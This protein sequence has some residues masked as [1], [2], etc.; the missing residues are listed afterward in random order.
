MHLHVPEA[1][2]KNERITGEAISQMQPSRDT[3]S[4]LVGQGGVL[5]Y[6]PTG[7]GR[8]FQRA[9]TQA[10]YEEI[11]E[12]AWRFGRFRDGEFDPTPTYIT[13]DGGFSKGVVYTL[14]YETIG[15]S[16][17]GLGLLAFVMLPPTS[18]TTLIGPRTHLRLRLGMAHHKRAEC[19]AISYTKD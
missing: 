4:L 19:F 13:K 5:T 14:V 18:S 6:E 12:N 15:A 3:S 8:L 9:H 16:I 1:L 2:E 10:P 17:V 11:D 7:R